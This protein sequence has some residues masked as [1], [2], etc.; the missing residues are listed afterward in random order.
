MRQHEPVRLRRWTALLLPNAAALA[1]FRISS[2]SW[3]TAVVT[4]LLG[5]VLVVAGGRLID[6]RK[7]RQHGLPEETPV[8]VSRDVTVALAPQVALGRVATVLNTMEFISPATVRLDEGRRVVRARTRGSW[9]CF[10]ERVLV[11]LHEVPVGVRLVVSSRPLWPGTTID[12]GKNARN[13]GALVSRLFQEG[14]TPD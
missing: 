14:G 1:I 12:Y 7:K 13:V 11:E 5:N 6:R 8:E 2:G 9:E 4:V 10:G 3:L